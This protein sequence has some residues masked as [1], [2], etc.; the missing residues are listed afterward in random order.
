MSNICAEFRRN[1]S[2]TYTQRYRVRHTE[3]VLTDGRTDGRPAGR[4]EN[5]RL[6][7]LLAAET[8][9]LTNTIL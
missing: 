2:T 4:P 3:L 5:I 9:E 6:S 8:K 7:P 1:P